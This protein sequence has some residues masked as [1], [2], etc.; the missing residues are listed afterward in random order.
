MHICHLRKFIFNRTGTIPTFKGVTLSNDMVGMVAVG[1]DMG[2]EVAGAEEDE[3]WSWRGL[4][5]M[6]GWS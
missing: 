1:M 4:A 5:K 3:G 2:L 6:Q